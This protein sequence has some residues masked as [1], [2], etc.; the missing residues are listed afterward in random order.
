LILFKTISFE[1]KL[2][3][4]IP[5]F[6]KKIIIL[7]IVNSVVGFFIK[8]LKLKKNMFGGIFDYKCVSNEEAAKIFWGVWE[9]AEIRFAKR[10][11]KSRTIIELGSS[12]GVTIGVLGNYLNNTKFICVEASP[13][14][15]D[16]LIIQKNLLLKK[17]LENQFVLHNRAVAYDVKVVNF[18]HTSTTGSQILKKKI[19]KQNNVYQIHSITLNDIIVENDINHPYT[20]I[21]D[22]EG[23]ESEIFFHDEQSLINC[24]TIIVE[25]ED[26][27]KYSKN[28]QIS[29]IKKLGFKILEFYGNVFVFKKI[30]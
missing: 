14:N 30:V 12:I 4:I 28:I 21:S 16:N 8:M 2:K 13:K 18:E 22:I 1:R 3:S 17:N 26:T 25:L 9:S 5:N 11:A 10:F 6:I 15:F 29:R 19:E 23:A 7:I 20:L 27:E 24:E